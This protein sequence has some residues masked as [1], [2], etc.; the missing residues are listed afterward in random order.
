MDEDT[1]EGRHHFNYSYQEIKRMTVFDNEEFI[2][3]RNNTCLKRVDYYEHLKE[4]VE[5]ILDEC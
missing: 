3:D 2:R 1:F 5:R 4:R